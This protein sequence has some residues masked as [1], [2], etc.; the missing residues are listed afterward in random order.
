M[1]R[2]AVCFSGQ[3]RFVNEYSRNILKN[4]INLYDTDVY[5][6]LWFDQSMIGKPFHHEFTDLYKESIDDFM[7]T[8]K[9]KACVTESC[10][11]LFNECDYN[12]VPAD[13]DFVSISAES[14]RQTIYR[15][16]SQWYSIKKS[17]ELIENPDQYDY[18]IR[19]RTDSL[20]T[21]PIVLNVLNTHTVYVQSGRQAGFDRKFCDW[22]AVGNNRVMA[23][24]MNIYQRYKPYFSSGIIHMH[25]FLEKVLAEL[26]VSVAEYEFGVH[27]SH[28]AYKHRK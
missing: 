4:L 16:E 25:I 7:H 21:K 22:F 1:T 14:I 12:F 3:L 8:Y 20:I 19:L 18:I 6:H 28:T 13:N 26:N 5:A 23:K 10:Y 15:M 17:Y 2:I 24:Y 9:P 11:S 27:I